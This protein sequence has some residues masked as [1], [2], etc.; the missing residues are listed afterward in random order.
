MMSAL[1]LR[2]TLSVTLPKSILCSSASFGCCSFIMHILRGAMDCISVL[3]WQL[4]C[5]PVAHNTT[6]IRLLRPA[7]SNAV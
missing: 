7:L 1:C 3:V 2:K 6:H 4:L 5:I